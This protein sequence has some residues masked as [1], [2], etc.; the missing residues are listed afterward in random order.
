M[1]TERTL[2]TWVVGQFGHPRG[3]WG[4]VVGWVM[5]HRPSNRLRN[6]WTVELL[7]LQQRD[8]VLEVGFGPGLALAH[9]AAAVGP[10]GHVVGV[11]RS[12]V[13]RHQATRRHA[14]AIAEGVVEL[15]VAPVESLPPFAEPF[16]A[17]YAVNSVG[18][19]RDPVAR[20]GELLRLLVPGGRLAL[21]VQPR[22]K[23]ATAATSAGVA[24]SLEQQMRDAGLEEVEVQT[25][26]LVDPPAV[27]VIGRRGR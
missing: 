8:R 25:L 1:K 19:W 3:S 9:A 7:D 5:A 21:T 10:G 2:R 18:F 13:M 16:E 15:H 26:D 12:L 22:S 24:A 11:D 17:I 6:R 14:R 23:G 4:R 20:L 27:C